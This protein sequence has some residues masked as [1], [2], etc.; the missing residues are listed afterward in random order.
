M[1]KGQ[2]LD[3]FIENVAFP[4]S[5]ALFH[6]VMGH[7]VRNMQQVIDELVFAFQSLCRNIREQTGIAVGGE[8]SLCSVLAAAESCAASQTALHHRGLR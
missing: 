6:Q 5:E 2:Q 1:N 7:F 8:T 3:Y 4:Q